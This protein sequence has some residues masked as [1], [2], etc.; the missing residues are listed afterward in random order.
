MLDLNL[1]YRKKLSTVCTYFRCLDESTG[2][3]TVV[4]SNGKQKTEKLDELYL[5]NF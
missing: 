3:V 4:E 1:F 5:F 2:W